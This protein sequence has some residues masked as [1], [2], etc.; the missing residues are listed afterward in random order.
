MFPRGLKGL[1]NQLEEPRERKQWPR[2]V[3][4]MR[5]AKGLKVALCG[6]DT[7]GSVSSV[8][9][10][11]W[12]SPPWLIP[13]FRTLGNNRASST[14][15][16]L[17]LADS[18]EKQGVSKQSP[19]KMGLTYCTIQAPLSFPSV[20]TFLPTLSPFPASPSSLLVSSAN[21]PQGRISAVSQVPALALW[22]GRAVVERRRCWEKVGVCVLGKQGFVGCDCLIPEGL[23]F[24]FSTGLTPLHGPWKSRLWRQK[25]LGLSWPP[26]HPV[27]PG[28]PVL[29][30]SAL[31]TSKHRLKRCLVC[32]CSHTRCKGFIEE[33]CK[34]FLYEGWWI[35]RAKHISCVRC[36]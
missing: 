3:S 6:G 25:T 8:R 13:L 11:Y 33:N 12:V 35:Q 9:G 29:C 27:P 14:L 15:L 2:V 26:C 4:Y 28:L 17:P 5:F 18:Q 23:S 32:L 21:R 10:C 31:Q 24:H 36:T 30:P 34:N 20:S 19:I 22:E 16:W 1:W 7:W